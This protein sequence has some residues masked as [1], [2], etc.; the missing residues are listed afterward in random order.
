MVPLSRTVTGTNGAVLEAGTPVLIELATSGADGFTFRLRG[1][2]V[3]GE[4]MSAEG[5]VAVSDA[6][7]SDRAVANGS[8][9]TKV[10]TG[11][12]AGAILGR[13]LG[14]GAKGTVIGAAAGAGAG[15]VAAQ[16]SRVNERCMAAGATITVTLSA[17]LV[18][19]TTAP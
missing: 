7:T 4:F 10:I 3:R 2:Q 8:D 16:R 15:T 1:V 13:I 18:L 6:T 19:P 14:G 12:V 17:P 11:A 5:S 9:K